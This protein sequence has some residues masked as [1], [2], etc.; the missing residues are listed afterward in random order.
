[1]PSCGRWWAASSARCDGCTRTIRAYKPRWMRSRRRSRCCGRE[2][3]VARRGGAA[4][5]PVPVSAIVAIRH[6]TGDAAWERLAQTRGV[7]SCGGA[8]SAM[9]RRSSPN[10]CSRRRCRPARGLRA[11]RTSGSRNLQLSTEVIRY[12]RKRWLLPSGETV[13]AALPAGFIGGFG[14]ELR[15]FVS[16]LWCCREAWLDRRSLTRTDPE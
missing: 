10:G 8:S 3:G 12:W 6:G 7:R 9:R 5:R 4:E 11:T 16:R 14:P 1:M 2:P 13:L 15:R